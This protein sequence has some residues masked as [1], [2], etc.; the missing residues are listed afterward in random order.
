M[1]VKAADAQDRRVRR[2]SGS[3][4]DS[5]STACSLC[6]LHDRA[7]WSMSSCLLLRASDTSDT[8]W[9]HFSTVVQKEG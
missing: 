7:L 2:Q 6:D 8:R 9:F 3:G 5:A 1:H 4:G